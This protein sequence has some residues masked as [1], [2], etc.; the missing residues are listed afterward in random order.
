MLTHAALHPQ[1]LLSAGFRAVTPRNVLSEPRHCIR[2]V[3]EEPALDELLEL[4]SDQYA[5]DIL[6]ATSERPMSANE[7]ADECNMSEPTVYRRVER[8]Q[9]YDLLSEQ[10][11][12]E[13]G[14]NNYNIYVATLSGLS[15]DLSDGRFESNLERLSEPAFPGENA[16]DTADR[17]TKMWE[18]L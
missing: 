3:S 4:L 1:R 11:Q 15:I 7:L 18:N 8:L 16:D 12:I 9:E 2:Y 10:Q 14:G 17:F 5:R 6:A 13:P